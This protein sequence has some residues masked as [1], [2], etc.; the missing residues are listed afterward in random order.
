MSDSIVV[1]RPVRFEG[2]RVGAVGATA[3][4]TWLLVVDALQ[5]TP[6]ST[7]V[8]LGWWLLGIDRVFAA[9]RWVDAAAFTAFLYLAWIGLGAAAARAARTSRRAPGVL[10]FAFLVFVL[11]QLA[12][13]VIT[14]ILAEAG[15]QE[16]AWRDVFLG[17][18]VGIGSAAW[19]MARRHPG[20]GRAFR[21]ASGD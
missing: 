21:A 10:L 14:T 15:M 16:T 4:W 6:F 1:E 8:L 19:Y 20:L 11:L 7:P 9:P 12:A 17:Q 3:A 18:L 5:R 13:V 2:L